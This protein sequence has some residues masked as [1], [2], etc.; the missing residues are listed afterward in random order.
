MGTCNVRT[1]AKHGARATVMSWSYESIT[2]Y[3]GRG[4]WLLREEVGLQETRRGEIVL[5]QE[6]TKYFT[7]VGIRTETTA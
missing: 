6:D 3:V 4:P 1:M 2:S 5:G 7:V